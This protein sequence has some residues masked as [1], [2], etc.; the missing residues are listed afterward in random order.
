MNWELLANTLAIL[1]AVSG[2][3]VF[4][5][6]KL[7]SHLLARDLERFKSDLRAA[8][9]SAL[10]RLRTDL[11]IQAFEREITF[12]R[13]HDKRV[14]V[15]EELYKRISAVS[16]AMNRLIS[17]IKAKDGPSLREQAD[18]AAKAGDDFLEY[19]LQHQIYFDEAL[20]DQLQ[21]FNG[22]I[23]D[24]WSKF[25]M[26]NITEDVVAHHQKRLEAWT[27]ISE[28]VPKIRLELERAFRT[29]LGHRAEASSDR[30]S[31]GLP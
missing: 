21:A 4:L 18:A 19:Y 9:D 13:L 7:S 1:A 16:L 10:E 30:A 14:Q 6:K 2:L 12:S 8:H 29:M 26:S 20:C 24:A 11:R 17:D 15:I 25:G 23:F 28:E 31:S 27:A 5:A 22:K 3:I